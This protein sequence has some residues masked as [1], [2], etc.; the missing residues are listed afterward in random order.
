MSTTTTDVRVWSIRTYDGVRGKTYKVRW[1]VDGRSFSK[2]Y[3][4]KPPAVKQHSELRK[5]VRR[6]V[7][8]DI[9]TG[10]PITQTRKEAI[11]PTWY[12]HAVAFMDMKWPALQP[13][14]RRSLAAGLATVT[15]ALTAQQH[16]RPDLEL[17]IK[18][19]LNWSFNRTARTAGDPPP[20]YAE[21]VAWVR[22]NS[23]KV[24]MLKNPRTVR[25][26]YNATLVAPNGK[27]Y[28]VHTH[29]NKMKGLTGAIRY[30]IELG[31]LDRNPLDRIST[32]RPRRT[33]FVDRRVVVNPEQA[34]ALIAAIA[35][36]GWTG[37]QYVALF[38]TIYFAGL[39]PAEALALRFQ[40]CSLPEQD[41]GELCFAEST[42]YAGAAWTDDGTNGPRKAL[43]HRTANESRT[44][45]AHPELVAHLRNHMEQ[46]GTAKDGRFFVRANGED[47]RYSSFASIWSR[48]RK[49][50]LTEAQ[51]NSPLGKRPY[52]LRHACISTWLNAG[53]SAP[54]IAEW[55]GHSVQMLLS[56]YAKCIDGQHDRDRRRIEEALRWQAAAPEHS[57]TQCLGRAS[58]GSRLAD[59]RS[60]VKTR[61][62]SEKPS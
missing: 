45:P 57:A 25:T 11:D 7:P 56:T 59:H 14:S 62:R 54:Q 52:D 32:P 49:A 8:F 20:Q 36:I 31:L 28:G 21:A 47:V 44:V 58:G 1:I 26:A 18:A 2:N 51:F 4:S 35:D 37:P 30:A 53:V 48:A 39:R 23:L 60:A 24:S 5:A 38:A 34:R 55:A 40:D 33:P 3:K 12:D 43:K 27:P 9:Y 50:V 41:W 10:L 61:R 42:P 15:A 16:R 22:K 46:F 17:C 19:L 13:N 6:A 29:R